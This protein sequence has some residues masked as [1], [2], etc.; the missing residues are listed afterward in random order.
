[1]RVISIPTEPTR[2]TAPALRDAVSSLREQVQEAHRV[3][4]ER[5]A[6]VTSEQ[7]DGSLPGW[8]QRLGA[9]AHALCVED[10]TIHALLKGDAP[11]FATTWADQ[12]QWGPPPPRFERGDQAWIRRVEGELSALRRYATAV[13]AATDLYLA[14]L[15]PEGLVRTVDL[16]GSGLGQPTVAW[17]VSRCLLGELASACSALSVVKRRAGAAET[18][19]SAASSYPPFRADPSP[20]TRC[21]LLA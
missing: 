5:L 17:V 4:E 19:T 13:F 18:P 21:G 9:Y 12:V 16:S 2:L 7:S 3:L 15:T 8:S 14:S 20:R 6:E 11:L 10:G 1:M